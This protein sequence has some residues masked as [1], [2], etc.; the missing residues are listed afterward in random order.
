HAVDR[1]VAALLESA[2]DLSPEQAERDRLE[3]AG[4]AVLEHRDLGP[5]ELVH[6]EQLPL[7][8]FELG[9]QHALLG[10]EVLDAFGGRGCL[11]EARL[12]G[13]EAGDELVESLGFRL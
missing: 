4:Y 2:I 13:L 7:E 10:L 12:V 5:R 6:Q 11:L 3:P 8:L 1:G 9:R